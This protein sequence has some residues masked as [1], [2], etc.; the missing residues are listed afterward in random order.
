[1][2]SVPY[3]EVMTEFESDLRFNTISEAYKFPEKLKWHVLGRRQVV[4]LKIE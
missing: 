1:M 2:R 3:T 4:L